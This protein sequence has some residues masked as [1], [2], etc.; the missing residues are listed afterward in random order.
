MLILKACLTDTT[1]TYQACFSTS[2]QAPVALA[3]MTGYG[4]GS[5]DSL[6]T[7]WSAIQTSPFS[8]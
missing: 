6:S 1:T 2:C 7:S 4:M 3:T 8:I 5:G